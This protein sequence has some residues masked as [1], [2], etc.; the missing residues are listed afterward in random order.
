MGNLLGLLGHRCL[1]QQHL[2]GAHVFELAVVAAVAD[3]LGVVDVQRDAGDGVEE[4]TVVADHDQRALVALE[5]GFEPD[6]GIQ[7]QVVGR[8]VEEQDVGRAHQGAGQLQAHAPAAGEAVDRVVQFGNLEAEAEDQR[9]GARFGVVF[10]GVVE[11]HVGF[12]HAHAVVAGFGVMY[13]V[14][15]GE[16]FGVAIDDEVGGRLLGFRHVLRH[17]AHLPLLGN[18]IIAAIL[19]QRTVEQREQR[20]LASAVAANQADLLTGI[21]GDGSLVE[22]HFRAATQGDVLEDDHEQDFRAGRA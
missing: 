15:G 2:L 22:Q 20:G 14:A 17:L 8:F 1:L 16:Q 9:L 12:G 10:A 18:R 5:P 19:M 3:E 13:L 21:D 11:R 6:Q 7:V 4:L